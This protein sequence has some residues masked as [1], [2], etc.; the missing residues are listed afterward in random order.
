[1]SGEVRELFEDFF[2][3]LLSDGVEEGECVEEGDDARLG[4]DD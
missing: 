3:V 1:M 4:V 2:A